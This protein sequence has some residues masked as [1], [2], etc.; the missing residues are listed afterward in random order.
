MAQRNDEPVGLKIIGG[1]G[2]FDLMLSVFSRKEVNF[3]LQSNAEISV[4]VTGIERKDD[5]C[6]SWNISGIITRNL[7]QQ[8]YLSPEYHLNVKFDAYYRTGPGEKG[9]FVV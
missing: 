1:P 9:W 5:S 4:I 8:F 3:K 7:L 6:E 2:K